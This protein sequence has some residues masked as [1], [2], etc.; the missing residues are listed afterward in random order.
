MTLQAWH[1]C[2]WGISRIPLCRSFQAL[3]GWMGSITAQLISGLSRDVRLGSSPGLRLGHSRKLVSKPLLRCLG[4]VLRVIVVMEGEPSPQS[5]VLSRFS[6]RISLYFALFSFPFILTSLPV[7]ATEQHPHSMMLPPLCFT[8]GFLQ[9][10][11]LAF[12][13]KS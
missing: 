3:S 4:C 12:R 6:S 5:E 8:V 10:W 9:T 11:R 1:T 7:P 2:I 13:P